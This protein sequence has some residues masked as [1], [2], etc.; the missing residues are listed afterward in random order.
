MTMNMNLTFHRPEQQLPEE[1]GSYICM[2]LPSLIQVLPYSS[3]HKRF[4]V[5]DWEQA[6]VQGALKV[7]WWAPK[8]SWMK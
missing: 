7:L 1:S 4:N 3:K 2:T 8:P 5:Y 6:P